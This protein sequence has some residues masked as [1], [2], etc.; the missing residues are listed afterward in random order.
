MPDLIV[1]LYII[2]LWAHHISTLGQPFLTPVQARVQAGTHQLLFGYCA[3]DRL[4]KS[5]E[6]NLN[7]LIV[8][9]A[10]ITK[11]LI[12]NYIPSLSYQMEDGYD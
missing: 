8:N 9:R 4:L 6:K 11:I 1:Q 3:L 7:D 10:N 12:H 2:V 5:R